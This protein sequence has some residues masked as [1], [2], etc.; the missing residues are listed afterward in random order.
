MSTSIVSLWRRLPVIVRAVIAGFAVLAIGEAPWGGIAGHAGLAGW[1]GRVWVGAPWALVPMALYLWLY[2]RYLGGAG[3]PRT[4]AEARRT[5]L[6][7]NAL[8]ADV[9]GM[10]LLAGLLGLATLLPL[11]RVLGR[12]VT[13]PAEAEP[14]TAPAHMPFATMFLLL[15][16]ASIVAGV[17]EE[18]A[19]RGYM[20]GPIERRYG[21]VVAIL[22]TGVVFGLAHYNHH[23]AAALT[24]LPFYIAVA[25]VYGGI[26]YATNSILPA[27][28]LHAAGDVFSLGRLWLTGQ[29][30]WQASASPATP[31]LVWQTGVDFPFVRSVIVFGVLSAAAIWAYS[32]LARTARA[33]PQAVS[34]QAS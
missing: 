30:E 31:T 18:T 11:S 33:A 16:M 23:P 19:F 1:N 5:S 15:V 25:A 14:I 20:Q 26:A 34:V 7:A 2:W 29:P 22:V 6:R 8:S 10:S 21:P 4:T 28:V 27:V 9:W 17:V 32:A 24:M 13:L 12:L 3:S